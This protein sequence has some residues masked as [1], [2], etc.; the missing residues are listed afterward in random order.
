MKDEDNKK[1]HISIAIGIS[2][3][4][5]ALAQIVCAYFGL[6]LPISLAVDILSV[7]LSMLVSLKVLSSDENVDMADMTKIIKEDMTHTLSKY[8][9][10]FKKDN[11]EVRESQIIQDDTKDKKENAQLS[12]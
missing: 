11:E 8:S 3:A 9:D 7:I 5:L 4:V 2:C 1:P 6:S 10:N 12:E